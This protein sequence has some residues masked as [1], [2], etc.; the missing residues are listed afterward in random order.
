MFLL[1]AFDSS[2]FLIFFTRSIMTMKS[3]DGIYESPAD[4]RYLGVILL[5]SSNDIIKHALNYS[6]DLMNT[7]DFLELNGK[8][9]KLTFLYVNERYSSK[10]KSKSFISSSLIW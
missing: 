5:H 8:L 9:F 4:G 3:G 1:R 6:Y 7:N 2:V 10:T